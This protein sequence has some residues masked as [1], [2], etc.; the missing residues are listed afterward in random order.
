MTVRK[1]SAGDSQDGLA[2]PAQRNSCG[3]TVA[4]HGSQQPKD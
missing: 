3:C 4:L 2:L 1:D